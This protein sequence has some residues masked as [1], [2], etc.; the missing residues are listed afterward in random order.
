MT[1]HEEQPGRRERLARDLR[2][3]LWIF[4]EDVRTDRG[5]ASRGF[6]VGGPPVPLWFVLVVAAAGL[7]VAFA[8][9]ALGLVPG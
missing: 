1:G 7:A 6:Y 9:I 2:R 8:I 5:W 3:R 4:E